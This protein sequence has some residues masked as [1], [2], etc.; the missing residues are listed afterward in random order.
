MSI[1]TQEV[2]IILAIEAIRSSKQFSRAKTA[3]IYNIL[4]STLTDRIN[5]RTPRQNYRLP[6]QKL[7]ELEEEVILRNIFE[8]DIKRFAFQLAG[9]EDITNYIF[10]SRGGK[11]INKFW[12]H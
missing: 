12:A 6:I 11:Y 1:Q 3:K 2:R 8:L 10:E 4:Y 9:M 5:G 7:T